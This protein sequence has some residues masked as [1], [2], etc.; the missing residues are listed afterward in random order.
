MNL[1]S[2]GTRAT[3]GLPGTG[4]SWS[5]TVSSSAPRSPSA[6]SSARREVQ[7]QRAAARAATAAAR[8]AAALEKALRQ[9]EAIEAEEHDEQ[10]V[11]AVVEW[12]R[13]LRATAAATRRVSRS[14]ST[15]SHRYAPAACAAIEPQLSKPPHPSLEID[16]FRTAHLA[17]LEQRL[18]GT[19]FRR[20]NLCHLVIGALGGAVVGGLV[21]R[22][23]GAQPSAMLV[24]GLATCVIA[25][26]VLAILGRYLEHRA[27]RVALQDEHHRTWPEAEAAVRRG[28]E[29]VAMPSMKRIEPASV[30]RS[31]RIEQ[32]YR[33]THKPKQRFAAD[34]RVTKK[35]ASSFFESSSRVTQKRARRSLRRHSSQSN[36]RSKQMSTSACPIPDASFSCSST[37]RR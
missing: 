9:R 33:S 32:R 8:E 24:A 16:T 11:E 35:L 6:P 31:P 10:S 37:C 21:S 34:G 36:S 23:A 29:P 2:R 15:T 3:I 1:S 27:F 25:T 7:A 26:M 18:R 19:S 5:G 17:E 20:I 28:H 4:I 30:E 12:W 13:T 22:V 14:T